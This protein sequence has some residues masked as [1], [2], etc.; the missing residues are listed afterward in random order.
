MTSPAAPAAA[1]PKL[2][3]RERKKARTRAA[4]RDQA[5]RLFEEQGYPATTIDQ[6]A[7]A[8][9]VSPSTF[10]RYFPTKEAVVL[11]DDFDPL[12]AAAIR[13]QPAEMHPID[14]IIE[15]MRVVFGQLTEADVAAE[16]RRQL[17]FQQVPELQARAMQQLADVIDL[18]GEVAAERAGLA[19][20]DFSAK[21]L[22]GAV[23]GAVMAVARPGD[24]LGLEARSL[25]RIAEALSLLRRG[26]PLG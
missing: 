7:D 16:R 11:T 10:F 15:G 9:E 4:I 12:I 24:A 13:A 18:L 22:A 3:L 23:V 17:L 6:I 1:F 25:E 26:L 19:P 20:D 21:V 8:A 2:G 14:A 5:M